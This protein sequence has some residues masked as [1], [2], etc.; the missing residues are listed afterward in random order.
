VDR[1]CDDLPDSLEDLPASQL[2]VLLDRSVVFLQLC[3]SLI[4]GGI[5]NPECRKMLEEMGRW[6][7]TTLV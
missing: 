5:T 2:R 6:I 3:Y 4:P 1:P 7:G